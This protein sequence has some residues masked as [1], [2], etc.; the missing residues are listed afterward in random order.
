MT[1]ISNLLTED[2][3]PETDTFPSLDQGKQFNTVVENMRNLG[4]NQEI[5]DEPEGFSG[6]DSGMEN[7]ILTQQTRSIINNNS[8]W[9]SN[10]NKKIIDDLRK[11]YAKTLKEYQDLT[12]SLSNDVS[13][14]LSTVNP[15]N[16]YLNK[17]IR[18]T[19]GTVA[20]V[21]SKGVAKPFSN[22]DT[23]LAFS[24]NPSNPRDS[25]QLSIPWT[26]SYNTP[27]A[28]IPTKPPLY[29]GTPMKKNQ[30]VGNEGTNVFVSSFLPTGTKAK[31]MGCYAVNDKNDNMTFIGNRP[32]ST[33]VVIQ[34]G[35]FDSPVIASNTFQYINASASRVPGWFFNA[36]LINNSTAWGFPIPY[37]N[38]N[39]CAVL[40]RSAQYIYQTLSLVEGVF[41]TVSFYSCGRPPNRENPMII[42]LFTSANVYVSDVAKFTPEIAKWKFHR[43]NFTVSKTGNY[44]LYFKGTE[45]NADKSTALQKITISGQNI[46]P[47][48]YTYDDCQ[49]AAIQQGY[50]Y[51]ALQNVNSNGNGYCTVSNSAPA[52]SQFGTAKT[53]GKLA[54]TWASNT[55]R[56]PGNYAILSS[57]GSLQVLNSA[58]AVIYSSPGDATFPNNYIGCYT[59][60]PQR[61]MTMYDGGKFLYDNDSCL[62]AANKQGFKYYGLQGTW[63]GKAQCA[64]SNDLAEA[65]KY[66]KA[67]NCMKLSN[68]LISGGGLSNA[69]YRADKPRSKYFLVI[70]SDGTMQ[71]NRGTGPNDNQG[72]IWTGGRKGGQLDPNPN[73]AASKGKYGRNWMTSGSVL[74]PGDFISSNDGRTSL[75]MEADGNLVL[76]TY[77]MVDNC[78]LMS[79]GNMGGGVLAN[80]SYDVGMKPEPGNL[81]KLGFVDEESNLYLYPSNN[82]MYTSSFSVINNASTL[83]NDISGASFAKASVDACTK[84]CVSNNNCAG[85][86][87]NKKDSVCYPKNKNMYPYGGA[88]VNT[89]GYDLYIRNRAP[90]TPPLGVVKDVR[91]I[92]SV[93]YKNYINKGT[94]GDKYGLPNVSTQTRKKL[95][96]LRTKMSSLTNQINKLTG[97]FQSD[98]KSAESQSRV[99]VIGLNGYLKDINDT[100]SKSVGIAKDNSVGVQNILQDSDIIVLQKNYDYLFWSI[101]AAGTALVSMNVINK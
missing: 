41:Y 90:I 43:F 39:Q 4:E 73:V 79:N 45:A 57:G 75:T 98:T 54:A 21:T 59:D 70:N 52:I 51:F 82:S 96:D 16:P 62:E 92:D 11:E 48:N 7:N 3:Q 83:Y 68:G 8:A 6:M 101:L 38:G 37:P 33:D 93:K 64:L 91:N 20:Y 100:N 81:G 13:G 67:T 29:S 99:N 12:N 42:Q 5:Q 2:I 77:Q 24:S 17:N 86:A 53:V 72:L 10:Q 69:I 47:G 58:G 49:N 78:K 22:Y 94:V 18:F 55:G 71:I 97:K 27:G 1:S 76:Y 36:V 25:I 46:K 74:G 85:F 60:K 61:A 23:L 32:P 88:I 9:N 65:Q 35:N 44:N 34:N 84:A 40:Q 66:G 19:N 89:N 80:A 15:S 26:G 28:I 30:S 56:Q 31:Y 50:Q 14:Y 63:N 87:Y 95:Q